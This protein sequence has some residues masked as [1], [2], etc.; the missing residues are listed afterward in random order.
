[1]ITKIQNDTKTAV[2]KTSKASEMILEE[3]KKA[4]ED[5]QHVEEVVEK[6]NRVIEEINSTSAATEELSSTFSE[7][8]MQIKDIANAAEEN[9]KAVEAVSRA[10]RSWAASH[11]RSIHW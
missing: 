7:M 8:D 2:E 4:E 9:L 5:K 10:Q 3:E 6:T 1:M 11:Q